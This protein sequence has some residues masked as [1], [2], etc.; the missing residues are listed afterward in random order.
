LSK[1]VLAYGIPAPK[2]M[3]EEVEIEKN[4]E[5]D[6]ELMLI[7]ELRAENDQLRS[8]RD[9]LEDVFTSYFYEL[10][11]DHVVISKLNTLL[12][13]AF[14]DCKYSDEHLAAWARDHVQKLMYRIDAKPLHTKEEETE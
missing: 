3:Q 1:I 6:D 7:S 11:R 12:I 10:A 5:K 2:V 13:N 9:K 4:T 14:P 8:Q